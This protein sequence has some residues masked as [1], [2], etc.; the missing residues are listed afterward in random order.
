MYCIPLPRQQILQ[1]Y[2][3]SF[4]FHIIRHAGSPAKLQMKVKI[5]IVNKMRLSSS[6]F[7]RIRFLLKIKY[8]DLILIF[9]T[10]VASL[11]KKI[12]TNQIVKHSYSFIYT[13]FLTNA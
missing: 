6:T 8:F 7:L 11:N 13:L 3:A 4:M 1:A 10:N 2:C 9:D 12:N 5:D